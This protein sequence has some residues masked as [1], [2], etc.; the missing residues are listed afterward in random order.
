MRQVQ[1]DPMTL[2]VRATGQSVAV[3]CF[4]ILYFIPLP[5]DWQL[6]S[7]IIVTMIYEVMEWSRI[8]SPQIPGYLLAFESTATPLVAAIAMGLIWIGAARMEGPAWSRYTTAGALL[9]ALIA[10]LAVAQYLGVANTYVATT[11]TSVPIILFGL[12]IPLVAALACGCQK[13]WQASSPRYR[14]PSSW[15]LRSIASG[16]AYSLCFGPADTCRG[17]SRCLRGLVTF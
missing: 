16:A 8:M 10:W 14:C 4:C 6:T 7:E 13:T 3:S 17:N 5:H 15:R 12:L 1:L 2:S 9:V 11:E